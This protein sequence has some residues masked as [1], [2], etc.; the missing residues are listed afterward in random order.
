MSGAGFILAINLFVAGLFAVAFLLV[1][2]NN[3]SDRT[4]YWFAAAYA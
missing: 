3:R 2:F 4:A 1:G